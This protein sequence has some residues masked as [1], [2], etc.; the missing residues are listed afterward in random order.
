VDALIAWKYDVTGV[1]V[2][3]LQRASRLKSAY[4]VMLRD[5]NAQKIGQYSEDRSKILAG[6]K[7][8]A[9]DALNSIGGIGIS[10]F[11]EPI[12]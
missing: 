3:I 1:P 5:P 4:T 11:N 9:E 12:D 6:M 8:E 10:A 2:L 7:A